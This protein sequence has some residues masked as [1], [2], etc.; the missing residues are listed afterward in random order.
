MSIYKE[1]PIQIRLLIPKQMLSEL[2]SIAR[3]R[4]VSRLSLIRRFLRH[5]IDDELKSL[6]AY[7]NE[8][9]RSDRTHR[10]LKQHLD[11]KDW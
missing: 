8:A 9:K 6:E 2:D 1:P 11:D 5:Q 3:S 10:L 4:Q 7:L